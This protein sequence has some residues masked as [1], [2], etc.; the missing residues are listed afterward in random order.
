MKNPEM[1][2]VNVRTVQCI[3][4]EMLKFIAKICDDH[5]IRYYLARGTLLGAAHC[6]G[7]L[8][9]DDDLD[10]QI[11]RPD[12]EKLMEVLSQST[13]PETLEF[14]SLGMSTH[15]LPYTKIYFRNSRVLEKKLEKCF[16]E[17]KIWIDVFPLDGLPSNLLVRNWRY[18]LVKQMRNFLYTG[19]VDPDEV[20]GFQRI[21]VI[22]L[23]PIAK[24]FGI[25]RIA[26]HIDRFARRTDFASSEVVGNLCWAR[27][28]KDAL[29]KS[30]YLPVVELQF[31]KSH[32]HAPQGYEEHLRKMYGQFNPELSS[33]KQA[34]HSLGEYYVVK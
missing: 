27:T 34:I 6:K 17:S 5:N 4:L 2:K 31:E 26:Y 1:A 18:F 32:F 23:K 25:H 8:R 3:Q 9:W 13:L 11:P 19:I 20:E 14:S 12:Y 33:E 24:A 21:G 28:S 29:E 30:K 15:H 16:R 10:I 7:F 22:V